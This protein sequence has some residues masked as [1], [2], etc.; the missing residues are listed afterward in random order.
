M[1]LN[2]ECKVSL[3]DVEGTCSVVC[4]EDLSVAV[5]DYSRRGT[6]RFYFRE[7]NISSCTPEEAQIASTSE[8]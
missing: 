7:V 5:E 1:Y 4:A 8:R 3:D 2:T 6:D